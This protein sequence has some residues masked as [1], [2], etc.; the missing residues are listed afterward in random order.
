MRAREEGRGD[1]LPAVARTCERDVLPKTL[2]VEL[3]RK[4]SPPEGGARKKLP[5]AKFLLFVTPLF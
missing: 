1:E 4:L 3:L 2:S 5:G